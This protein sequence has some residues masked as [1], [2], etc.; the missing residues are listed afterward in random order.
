MMPTTYPIH[1]KPLTRSCSRS[2]S[3]LAVGAAVHGSVPGQTQYHPYAKDYFGRVEALGGGFANHYYAE[4]ETKAALS[5]FFRRLDDTGVWESIAELYLMAGCDFAGLPAKAKYVSVT[6]ITW[7]NFVAGDYTPAGGATIGLQG[8]DG[9]WGGTGQSAFDDIGPNIG[10]GACVTVRGLEDNTGIIIG[11]GGA[12][13]DYTVTLWEGFGSRY[14]TRL[15]SSHLLYSQDDLEGATT[16]QRMSTSHVIAVTPNDVEPNP[17]AIAA[18]EATVNS[19]LQI[20]RRSS[21][22]YYH[23]RAI[24]VW[25]LDGATRQQIIDLHAAVTSLQEALS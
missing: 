10:L 16:H 1:T 25:V 18:G 11:N 19:Q 3:R 14:G 13:N 2:V 9:K 23:G 8:G 7:T 24:A 12:A 22:T 4:S 6:D 15:K 20:F 21:A 17:V 5:D